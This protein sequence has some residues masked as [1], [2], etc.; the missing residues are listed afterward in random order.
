MLGGGRVNTAS[1]DAGYIPLNVFVFLGLYCLATSIMCFVLVLHRRCLAWKGIK[2][3]LTSNTISSHAVSCRWFSLLMR[4]NVW[5]ESGLHRVIH[6]SCR[7]LCLQHVFFRSL[8]FTLTALLLAVCCVR[9]ICFWRI[10]RRPKTN[11]N[12][13]CQWFCLFSLFI[14][15]FDVYLLY[16]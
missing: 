3:A 2:R 8:V 16:V 1:Q 9:A 11:P 13:L 5:L 12:P 14:Q 4:V 7:F 10:L 6:W 15:D